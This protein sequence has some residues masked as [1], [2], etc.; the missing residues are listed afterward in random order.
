MTRRST[1]LARRAIAIAACATLAV[2]LPAARPAPLDQSHAGFCAEAQR[3]LVGTTLPI[4]NIVETDFETFKRAKPAVRPLR[5]HQ[6]LLS[7][8]DG[9]AQQLSCTTKTAAPMARAPSAGRPPTAPTAPAATC[10]AT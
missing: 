1:G 2:A 4:E 9:R 8:E 7:D 6:Y 3:R 5:T 10:T